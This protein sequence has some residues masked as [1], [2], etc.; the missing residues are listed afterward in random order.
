[1]SKTWD[2]ECPCCHAK[3][4]VDAKLGAILSHEEPPASRAHMEM[5]FGEAARRLKEQQDRRDDVFSQS[6][7]NQRKHGDVLSRKFDEQFKKVKDLPIEKPHRDIDF[8]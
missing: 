6:V 3:M 7:E 1:M 5:D 8:D 4:V 2:V